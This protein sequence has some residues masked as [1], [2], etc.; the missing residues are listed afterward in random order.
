MAL[1]TEIET[2]AA[3]RFLATANGLYPLIS[4]LHILGI[5]LLL[6]SITIV[7][8]RILQILG[9]QLDAALATLV[10]VAICGFLIAA[11]AGLLLASVRLTNYVVNPAFQVKLMLLMLAGTNALLLRKWHSFEH[12]ARAVGT[13]AGAWASSISLLLWIATLFAGRWIAF[14]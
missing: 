10:R 12:S 14:A 6:G 5:A 7:D 13:L 4:A 11:T 8:L 2:L 9:P 3:V 1:L